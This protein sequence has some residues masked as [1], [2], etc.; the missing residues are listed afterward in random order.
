MRDYHMVGSF[1]KNSGI[2]NCNMP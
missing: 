1:Y 2:W